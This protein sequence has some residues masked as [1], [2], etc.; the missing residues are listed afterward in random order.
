M[1]HIPS[2]IMAYSVFLSL[3]FSQTGTIKGSISDRLGL[4]LPGA[5]IQLKET[6]LGTTSNVDGYFEFL[7]VPSGYYTVYVTYI[8]YEPVT[9]PD[10]WVRP[11]AYDNIEISLSQLVIE[12]DNVLVEDSY[13]R[14]SGLNQDQSVTFRNDEIRRAPGAGQELSR[15]LNSL[16]SVASVGENRQDMMVRGGGPT[17]NGFVID[18]IPIPSISHFAQEDGRSNGP[19]GLINTEMVETL[20]FYS[21]GFSAAYGNRLSSYGDITYRNG[22]KNEFKGNASLGLGGAAALMEGPLNSESSYIFSYRRSYLDVIAGALNAGGLPSYDDIQGKITYQPNPYNALSF[23]VVSGS[24]LYERTKE[25]AIK[26]E[27]VNYGRRQNNQSTIGMNYKKIWNES[28]FSNTSIS[29][30]DQRADASFLNYKTSSVTSMAN[31]TLQSYSVRQINQTQISNKLGTEYGFETSSKILQYDFLLNDLAASQDVSIVN[32]AVFSTF[33]YLFASKFLISTGARVERN[34]YEKK[35]LISPRFNAKYNLKDGVSAL[36]YNA[37]SYYQN[38][39]EIYLSVEENS[40]LKSVRT[41]QHSITYERLLTSSTKLTLAYYQK[42]YS[43]AP[44]LSSMLARTE[45][46]FL[47]DRLA[48]Y[49]GVVSSGSSTTDGIE[50]LIEKKRAENFYGLIGATYFNAMYDDFDNIS[51]NRDYNYKYIMNVVGGYRPE[52]EWEFSV[53]WSYFGGKP[54]TPIDE[55]KSQEL[56]DEVLFLDQWNERRTPAYHSLFLRYENHKNFQSGNLIFFVEF[57]NAYNRENIETYYWEDRV[58][59]VNYFNFIP[60]GGFEYEF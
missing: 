32:T 18:N 8:G 3:V 60:V 31:N 58:R 38:P 19:I 50:L 25:D 35:N 34:D 1:F 47:L 48:M 5:N 52:A 42:T 7:N 24:S 54:Y 20:E 30:S 49:S 22:D 11:N 29:F 28:S 33:R 14:N 59:K 37:G 12:F 45:P 10:V 15:I 16:P 26:E 9:Y 43:D 6:N 13:F 44:M 2:K 17:E 51:R 21:N 27:Q 53:R 40:S 55:V 39:P 56:G 41:F 36:I 4:P 46:T 57:W 23:L